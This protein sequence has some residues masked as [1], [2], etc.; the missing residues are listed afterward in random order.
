M[1]LFRITQNKGGV[2]LFWSVCSRKVYL[3]PRAARLYPLAFLFIVFKRLFI[4]I[5]LYCY[6]TESDSALWLSGLSAYI[7]PCH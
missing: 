1:F 5:Y 3:C 6:L 4:I 7:R 2:S